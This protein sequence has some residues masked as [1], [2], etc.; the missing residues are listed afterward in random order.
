MVKRISC[1]KSFRC[2]RR[3]DRYRL[4]ANLLA[5]AIAWFGILAVTVPAHTQTPQPE[6]K[7]AI[8]E[9]IQNYAERHVDND[10]PMQTGLVVNLYRDNKVGLTPREIATIYELK[11]DRLKKAKQSDIWEQLNAGL[12]PFFILLVLFIL[13]DVLKEWNSNL[14]KA[15]GAWLYNRFSGTALFRNYS[16]KRYRQALGEKYRQLHVPFRPSRPLQMQN[17][18]VPLKVAGTSDTK[19]LDA[20]EAVNYYRKL[21]VTGPPGSGKSML[22]K[23]IALRY[24]DGLLDLPEQPIAIFLEMHRLSD[25]EKSLKQHLVEALERDDFPQIGRAHV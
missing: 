14:I 25:P 4:L 8:I 22:L 17:V 3:K 20:R 1:L 6:T 2:M 24:A 11:Y 15:I 9:E 18:Y 16:L 21:M 19:Q 10:T 13:Q 7:E 23:H 5:I 12:I